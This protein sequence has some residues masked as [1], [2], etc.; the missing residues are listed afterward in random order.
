MPLTV[1]APLSLLAALLLAGFADEWF[2]YWP[3]GSLEPIKAD[4]GLSYAQMGLAVGSL[5]AG[6]LLGH[7][8]RVAADFVD[9]RW[10]ASLGAVGVAAG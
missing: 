8:F 1:R 10:L 6:G 5:T 7:F 3:F 2:T 9:R 4:L